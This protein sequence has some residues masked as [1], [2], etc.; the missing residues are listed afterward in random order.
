MTLSSTLTEDTQKTQITIIHCMN[1]YYYSRT[2][3]VYSTKK[4]LRNVSN[5]VEKTHIMQR[6]GSSVGPIVEQPLDSLLVSIPTFILKV[7]TA[8]QDIVDLFMKTETK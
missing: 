7:W 5:G 4:Q 3:G 8:C 1:R 6:K 2:I